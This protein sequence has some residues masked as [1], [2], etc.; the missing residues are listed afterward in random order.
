MMSS[1]PACSTTS[2]AGVDD[3]PAY[4][5]RR[6]ASLTSMIGMPSRIS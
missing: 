4:F 6:L 1:T 2:K 5:S 3:I